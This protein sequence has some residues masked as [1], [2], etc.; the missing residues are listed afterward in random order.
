MSILPISKPVDSISLEDA[1]LSVSHLQLGR[2][3]ENGLTKNDIQTVGQFIRASA[4]PFD[5]VRFGKVAPKEFGDAVARLES[6]FQ[7][8][9][10][11]DWV[12]YGG[13]SNKPWQNTAFTS[14][15]LEDLSTEV[16]A[17]PLGTLHLNKAIN[18]LNAVGIRS[19][20]KLVDRVRIGLPKL[21]SFGRKAQNEVI[22][23]LVALSQSI[24]AVGT[25]DWL[26]FARMR[27]FAVFP[28]TQPASWRAE[29]FL[30][31]L[32]AICKEA[33]PRQLAD[34]E[35]TIFRKRLLTDPE[36]RPTLQE[37]GDAFKITRERVRQLQEIALAVIRKPLLLDD[38]EDLTFRFRPELGT[39]LR[40]AAE[41]FDAVGLVA[42]I[43]DRWIDELARI[44]K[45]N[46][47]LIRPHYPLL[48]EL[49][50]YEEVQPDNGALQP[51]LVHKSATK[52][53][54]KRLRAVV[55][56]IHDVLTDEILGCEPFD[57]VRRINQRLPVT[58]SASIDEL[59]SFVELCSSVE[60][61]GDDLY[62]VRFEYLRGRG[63]Q[64]VRLLADHGEPMH[65]RELLRAVNQVAAI[66][67]KR[68]V[69]K[70]GFVNQ[71]IPDKRLEPIGKTG[72]WTLAEW[73]RETR[74]ISDLIVETLHANG[75][76]MTEEELWTSV[77]SVRPASKNSIPLL[78]GNNPGKFRRVAPHVWGLMEWGDR[79]DLQWW[80]KDETAKFIVGFFKE[81]GTDRVDF[82]ELRKAFTA[83][84]GLSDRSAGGVLARHP[85]IAVDRP[86]SYIRIAVF[87]KDWQA[88][89]RS[90]RPRRRQLGVMDKISDAI[91]A[92]LSQSPTR[93]RPLIEL[94]REL[95]V[96]YKMIRQTVYAVV[97]QSDEFEEVPVE[98]SAFKIC[99]FI[100]ETRPEFPQLA[101]LQNDNWRNECSRG[102]SSLNVEN[103]DVGLF[104][105]GRQFDSAMEELLR[106]AQHAGAPPVS[107]HDQKKLYHRIDWA[108][109]H[110]VFT[111]KATA[112]LLRTQR[113]ERGHMPPSETERRAMMKF[114][115]YM[116]S[117]YLDY[118]IIIERA[119]RRWVAPKMPG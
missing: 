54:M 44:W 104:I 30:R 82:G 6:A 91:R 57:L 69:T 68:P 87:Q 74:S 38:Y 51:F 89:S 96:E 105:L 63:D 88:A 98:G 23:A 55:D 18:P 93:E 19:V 34:R 53:E 117:L 102:L 62:R 32:P 49:L 22:D 118:L 14:V 31:S 58:Q 75:E 41:H 26:Q 103:V 95:E 109:R 24:S 43:R 92:K 85:A 42:W 39:P 29:H 7:P 99:R 11:I 37:L 77:S 5:P 21:R 33:I 108:L 12:A 8:N 48:G 78:L 3:A 94:V 27:S 20:G 47:S 64:V 59:P 101:E 119:I 40:E 15:C 80:D 113:N 84:S 4:E 17:L 73:G 13:N 60:T 112:D 107:D 35:W 115:P 90:G 114:A 1:E 66:R 10:R 61:T 97:T 65:H 46:A 16:R 100:G 81:A 72:A 116:A 36:K 9:G 50:S 28:T 106:S 2:V 79:A 76:A 86:N 83:V 25:V 52:E 111:D 70:G 56:A 45:L 67:H 110:G 71:L